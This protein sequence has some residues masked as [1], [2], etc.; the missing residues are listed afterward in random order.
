MSA[1]PTASAP[2]LAG[3]LLFPLV[4]PLDFA[5]PYE[6]LACARDQAGANLGRVVTIA[7]M[8]EVVCQ[9]GLRVL[10]DHGLAEAPELDVLIVPGGPGAR[11]PVGALGPVLDFLRVRA[12]R[13]RV[14]ASVCTGAYWLARAG[15]LD[16]RR[17]TTH[18]ARLADFGARFPAVT[19]VAEKVVDEGAIVTAGGVASGVDLALHLLERFFGP[20]ARRR[21]A[22]RLDGPWR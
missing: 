9:G 20:E 6:V 15:F 3:I 7:Q 14:V 5:G 13:A 22:L 10:A 18:S 19:V 16:G 21:E 8:P 11:Q 17:A 2:L 4:E 1:N 12:A